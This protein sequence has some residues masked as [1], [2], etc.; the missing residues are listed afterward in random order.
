MK[1]GGDSISLKHTEVEFY[2]DE[3]KRI[4]LECVRQT[5]STYG[6]AEKSRR[7]FHV[8]KDVID[9]NKVSEAGNNIK[10]SMLRIFRKNKLSK[11]DISELK[12]LGFEIQ[13]GSHDKYLFHGDHRYIITVSNSPSDYR[14]GE[15]LAHETV[16]LIFGRM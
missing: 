15:N 9:N 5:I 4:I 13:K 12:G 8:L 2:E 6:N 11:S 7:D 3:I 1:N 16:N 10:Q 14:G